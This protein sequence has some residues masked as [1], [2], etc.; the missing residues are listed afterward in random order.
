MVA[1]ILFRWLGDSRFVMDIREQIGDKFKNW[2]N[3]L[4]GVRTFR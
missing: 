3:G 4:Q 2:D 1:K